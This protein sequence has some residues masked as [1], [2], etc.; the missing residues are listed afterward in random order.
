VGKKCLFQNPDGRTRSRFEDNITVNSNEVGR[1]DVNWIKLA[2]E[3][4]C[5]FL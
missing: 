5:G 2:K 1:K 3:L 4:I